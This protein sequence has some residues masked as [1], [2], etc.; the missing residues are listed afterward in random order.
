MKILHLISSAGMYGAEA[1]VLS[2]TAAQKEMGHEPVIGVFH[3]RHQPHLEIA[4]EARKRDLAVEIFACNGRF[5]WAAVRA[6]RSFV[7]AR[8]VEVVHTH[9]YKS[10]IYGRFAV[11]GLSAAFVATCHLWTRGTRSVRFY[12]FLDSFV[13]RSARRVVGVSDVITESLA[14]SGIPKSKLATISNGTDLLRFQAATP[15]LREEMGIGQGLLIGTVGRLET[16]K[17]M[18]YFIRAAR[19]VIAVFPDTQFVVV[20]EGSLR[21][22]LTELI[23]DLK[24]DSHVRLLGER[25]DIPGVYASLDLFALASI[26]EGMPMVILEALASGR[27]VVATRVGAVE[28]LVL[29]EVTGLLVEPGDVTGLREAMLRCLGNPAFARQLAANGAQHVR[30][31]FSAEAMARNY[32]EIYRQALCAEEKSPLPVCQGS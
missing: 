15:S 3:N 20:G 28:K 14:R 29:P 16:Q 2:L 31:S 30:R 21:S 7:A 19:E 17:G 11:K 27:P 26:A 32:S 22:Q 5:D 10:D 12:E 4:R 18:E 24:L 6:I 13:L 8:S 25:T 9:G 23:R 1:V